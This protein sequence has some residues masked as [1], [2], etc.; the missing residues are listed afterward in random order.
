MAAIPR[1][2]AIPMTCPE[3]DAAAGFPF[4]ATTLP[5]SAGI[6][7]GVRCHA[8]RHEW[9]AFM[10]RVGKLEQQRRPEYFIHRRAS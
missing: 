7:L 1:V 2:D 10:E 6:D 8:C 5:D 3:C 4:K 9:T